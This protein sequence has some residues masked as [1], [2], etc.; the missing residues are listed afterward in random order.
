MKLDRVEQ[1]ELYIK[2]WEVESSLWNVMASENNNCNAKQKSLKNV[3]EICQMTSNCDFIDVLCRHLHL[4]F[5][6]SFLYAIP[7]AALLFLEQEVRAKI[8]TLRTYYSEDLVKTEQCN[9]SGNA[10]N[11]LSSSCCI[12]FQKTLRQEKQHQI[13]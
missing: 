4:Y 1:T 5:S 13:L 2:V 11:G 12:S 3:A 10:T 9:E 7:M 6:L 8:N